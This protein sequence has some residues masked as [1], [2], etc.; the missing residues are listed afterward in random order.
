MLRECKE[1]KGKYRVYNTIYHDK[2]GSTM[3]ALS[4]EDKKT[5]DGFNPSGVID[6]YHAHET[7]EIYDV[8]GSGMGASHN[9]CL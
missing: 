9:H 5:G 4:K 1:L 6:E 3:T 8:I 2:S 7:T